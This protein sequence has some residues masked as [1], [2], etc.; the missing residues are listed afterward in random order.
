[1]KEFI[2]ALACIGMLSGCTS[3]SKIVKA[4]DSRIT[5][6]FGNDVTELFSTPDKVKFYLLNPKKNPEAGKVLWQ[7]PVLGEGELSAELAKNLQDILLEP[8]TYQFDR[9]KKGFLFP[10]YGFTFHKD[11]RE[12]ILLIDFYRNELMFIL[13]K[14]EIKEDFDSAVTA[15]SNLVQSAREQLR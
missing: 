8:S 14:K 6:A 3:P 15:M 2:L 10:E 4:P 1:M 5:G 7:Y 12:L 13:D 11:S 9:A